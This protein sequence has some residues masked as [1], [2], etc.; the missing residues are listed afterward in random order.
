MKK[1]LAAERLGIV[2]AQ[3]VT[4]SD[5]LVM[6]TFRVEDTDFKGEPPPSRR[7]EVAR[8]IE[9]VLLG[10]EAVESLFASRFVPQ[11]P[12]EH[13]ASAGG[14][15]QVHLDNTT[16]DRFT[17][18]ELFA[19]DRLDDGPRKSVH[20]DDVLIQDA[21]PTRRDR[22]HGQLRMTGRSKLSNEKDVERGIKLAGDLI[23]NRNT[24]TW[25]GKDDNLSGR[26]YPLQQ[27][28]E[29]ATGFAAIGKHALVRKH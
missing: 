17:I 16:S 8:R 12:R 23:A 29:L 24:A 22:P 6:D 18:V 20:G 15:P 11:A 10:R 2:S 7:G 1:P 3:I 26:L 28:R 19:D 14:P 13:H 27:L 4:R 9:A 5:G 21:D 25:K